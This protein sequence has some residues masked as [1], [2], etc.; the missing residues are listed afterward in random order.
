[1]VPPPEPQKL[2]LEL[3]MLEGLGNLRPPNCVEKTYLLYLKRQALAKHGGLVSLEF[4]IVISIQV[5]D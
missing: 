1:M 4:R 2:A 5:I 3:K